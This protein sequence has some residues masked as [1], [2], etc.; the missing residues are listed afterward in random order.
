MTSSKLLQDVAGTT[1][2]SPASDIKD[3]GKKF[4]QM[5]PSFTSIKVIREVDKRVTDRMSKSSTNADKK[6]G[7]KKAL[8]KLAKAAKSFVQMWKRQ[9]MK[10]MEE[11][12]LYV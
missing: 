10:Q 2:E 12:G 11:K 8:L 6:I 4:V 1:S 3:V 5:K 9:K 7:R